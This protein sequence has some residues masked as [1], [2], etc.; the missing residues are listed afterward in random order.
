MSGW[1]Q[2]TAC[3]AVPTDHLQII[4]NLQILNNC[5]TVEK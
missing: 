5:L 3:D 4:T 2:R 1:G